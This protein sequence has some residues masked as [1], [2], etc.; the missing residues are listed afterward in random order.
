MNGL[1]ILITR[2]QIAPTSTGGDE[3][4]RVH[5]RLNYTPVDW[6]PADDERPVSIRV[7]LLGTRYDQNAVNLLGQRGATVD[8]PDVDGIKAAVTT[9]QTVWGPLP[10]QDNSGLLAL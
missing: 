3:F 8:I 7:P 10:V 9:L 6:L 1:N 4:Y 5:V 2:K